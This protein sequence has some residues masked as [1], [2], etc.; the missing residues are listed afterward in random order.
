MIEKSTREKVS[1]FF[2]RNPSKETHLRGL[3]RLLKLSMPTIISVTDDLAKENFIIKIKSGFITQVQANRE[4]IKFI[5]KKRIYNLAIVFESGIVE[6]LVKIYNH[7]QSII[8]FGSFSRGDDIEKSDVDIAVITKKKVDF[9]A[10]QYEKSL[11][12]NISIHEIDLNDVSKEFRLNLANG[13]VL[14]GSW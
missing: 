5:R 10:R 13:I 8:L 4:S 14:E 3:S 9:D 1:E 2:F 6:H 11:G 12:R 7:P